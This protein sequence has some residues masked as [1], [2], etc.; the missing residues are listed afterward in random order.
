MLAQVRSISAQRLLA[1]FL[2]ATV[3]LWGIGALLGW[4]GILISY[5]PAAGGYVGN[6]SGFAGAV[7]GAPLGGMAGGMLGIA[8]AERA[9]TGC[10]PRPL[11]LA[12]TAVMV[13]VLA[14]FTLAIFSRFNSVEEQAGRAVFIVVPLFGAGAVLGWLLGMSKAPT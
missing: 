8:L 7:I 1:A 11:P 14:G 5:N 6:W 4:L 9:F 2:L 12:L 13:L 3:L 10:W